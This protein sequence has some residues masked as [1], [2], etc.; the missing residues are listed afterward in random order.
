M[1]IIRMLQEKF[2]H[3][4]IQKLQTKQAIENIELEIL[5]EYLNQN[6]FV[7]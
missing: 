5:R 4:I 2:F 1:K 7:K 3:P 6:E